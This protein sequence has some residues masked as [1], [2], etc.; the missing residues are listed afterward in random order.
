MAQTV[1][2]AY[3]GTNNNKIRVLASHVSSAFV[4]IG[5]S[6]TGALGYRLSGLFI[7]S[8]AVLVDNVWY[9]LAFTING[10]NL[11]IYVNGSLILTATHTAVLPDAD[12]IG[13]LSPY[14]VPTTNG[15]AP[16]ADGNSLSAPHADGDSRSTPKSE[17]GYDTSSANGVVDE[18]QEYD[19]V[20]PD[21]ALAEIAST[22]TLLNPLPSFPL[23]NSFNESAQEGV[24]RTTMDTGYPKI[25]TRFSATLRYIT[26]QYFLNA[27]QRQILDQY[28]DS[29][30]G[31]LSF[32]WT[33][34]DTAVIET[35][36]FAKK[37]TYQL[38]NG[39]FYIASVSLEA[40]P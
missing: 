28:Y 25:R 24:I 22:H 19:A 20:L 11:S 32:Y 21:Y 37:P 27:N 34:P 9:S 6:E 40:L 18:L 7:P 31:S 36:R 4:Y 23:G 33:N 12:R 39:I 3:K 13:N 1:V 16:R 10:A 38:T 5:I 35:V 14:A 17:G 29:L 15:F 30:G 26:C 2:M 8:S